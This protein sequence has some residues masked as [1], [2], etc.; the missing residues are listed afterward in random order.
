MSRL[1]AKVHWAVELVIAPEWVTQLSFKTCYLQ[2][3]YREECNDEDQNQN[4][5][6]SIIKKK[7]ISLIFVILRK[8]YRGIKPVTGTVHGANCNYVYETGLLFAGQFVTQNLIVSKFKGR[9]HLD[10]YMA[11]FSG[12]A[13]A[14]LGSFENSL[15]KYGK[16][17]LG[18]LSL[19][20]QQRALRHALRQEDHRRG[21]LHWLPYC[22]IRGGHHQEK[23]QVRNPLHAILRRFAFEQISVVTVQCLSWI[24]TV[25][26]ILKS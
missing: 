20:R 18:L 9:P 14:R 5:D 11:E 7:K 1:F 13:C 2:H 25:I 12:S 3:S 4:R 17:G 8:W 16:N 22:Q 26:C 21:R 15:D 24:W 6:I 19:L 10:F 23:G